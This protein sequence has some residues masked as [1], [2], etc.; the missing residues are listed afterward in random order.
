SAGQKPAGE[1]KDQRKTETDP[2]VMSDQWL[3]LVHG[4]MSF[5]LPEDLCVLRVLFGKSLADCG[6]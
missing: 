5:V 2:V 1:C 3:K 4:R 6:Y